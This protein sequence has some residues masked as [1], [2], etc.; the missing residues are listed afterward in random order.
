M[1]EQLLRIDCSVGELFQDMLNRYIFKSS[2]SIKTQYIE[3]TLL[4]PSRRDEHN[5]GELC[6]TLG[7]KHMAVLSVY[8]VHSTRRCHVVFVDASQPD[9]GRG[10]FAMPYTNILPCTGQVLSCPTVDYVN[11]S[12]SDLC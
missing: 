9:T 6:S 7:V 5:G 12:N 11:E 10:L 2:G 8:L 3:R 4:S 1:N